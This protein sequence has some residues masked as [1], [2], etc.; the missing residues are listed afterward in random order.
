MEK[1]IIPVET[2]ANKLVNYVCGSNY[3]KTGE[4]IK[5]SL[6]QCIINDEHSE[7]IMFCC[8]WSPTRSIP[9]GYGVWILN[10]LCHWKSWIPI[11]KHTG[12]ACAKWHSDATISSRSWKSFRHL[13]VS[14]HWSH[15]SHSDCAAFNC[16]LNKS[17]ND[18]AFLG[19][20]WCI[21]FI[22]LA[23]VARINTLIIFIATLL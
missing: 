4:D 10:E 18:I 5:V 15:Y 7:I 3:L 6:S 20:H 22:C 8:S 23:V 11:Q 9:A 19:H 12:A 16:C 17:C 14:R 13:S 21:Y 1:K 2:D